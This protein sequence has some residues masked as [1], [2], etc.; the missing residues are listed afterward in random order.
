MIRDQIIEK[1]ASNALCRCLLRERELTLDN[2]LSIARSFELADR[3]ALEIEPKFESSTHFNSI[4]RKR[5]FQQPWRNSAKR[6]DNNRQK[7]VCYCCGNEGHHAK[8]AQ[9][10]APNKT[11]RTHSSTNACRHGC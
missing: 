4:E 7:P 11:C 10:P 1:C 3:Q 9:F 2:L 8:D 6:E 5:D